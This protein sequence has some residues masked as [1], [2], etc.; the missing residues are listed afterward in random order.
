MKAIAVPL[1]R[2]LRATLGGELERPVLPV[3]AVSFIYSASFS[4][5]WI[6][7]G[8]YV[9]KGL[10]WPAGRVGVLFLLTAPTAAVANYL[11][12][13]LSDRVGRKRLIVA[14]FAL[15]SI[16]LFTLAAI[17]RG[18]VLPF[19]LIVLQGVIGAPA[20]SLDRVVATDL[21]VD[22]TR[23]E[24]AFATLR[25]GTNLGVFSGPPL[26]ALLIFAG[27]WSSF[28]AGLAALGVLGVLAASTLLPATGRPTKRQR[29]TAVSSRTVLRDRPFAL[30][31]LSTL[32]AFTD[33]CGFEAVLPV[34][35]VT[36]YGLSPSTWGLLVVISPLLVVLLQLRVTRISARIPTAERLGLA[37]LLM[38]LPFLA[39]GASAEVPVIAGVIV[40]FILGEMVWMPTSQAVAAQ[41]APP[42]A[43]GS[44]FG[45]LAAMTGPA[46]TL[47]PLIALELRSHA[48]VNSVWL[49]FAAVAA[50]GAVT[51]LIA[52]HASELRGATRYVKA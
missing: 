12:G 13:R 47:A 18:T 31:L 14:S 40:V 48:G 37:T 6:Y 39:L 22:R 38:G 23:R 26:A 44:Y 19:A 35:A 49:F 51:G 50:A 34:I 29:D 10:G 36:T 9:V 33:Y 46:W 4:T 32:L 15:S 7:V 42:A 30:L 1:P 5:F 2:L 27:G 28:L 21:V 52:V 8:V 45:A 20:Y 16:N 41:L 24:S 3:A 43:R 11:S 17:G 25:V